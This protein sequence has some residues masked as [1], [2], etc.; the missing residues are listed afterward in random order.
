MYMWWRLLLCLVVAPAATLRTTAVIR[1]TTPPVAKITGAALAAAFAA[2]ND[3][4]EPKQ[5]LTLP[6]KEDAVVEAIR[7]VIDAGIARPRAAA[8]ALG[9]FGRCSGALAQ[10][11]L[12]PQQLESCFSFW[13]GGSALLARDL[14]RGNL[15]LGDVKAS[16]WFGLL[17]LNTFPWTP[18]LV[19]LVSRAIN[20]TDAGSFTPKSFSLR[21]LAALR[22]LR[23]DEGLP[24]T[25][26]DSPEF[27]T[28]QNIDEGVRFF[29]DGFTM[30]TRDVRLGRLGARGDTAAA[31]GWFLLL[32][33]STFPLTPL[34]LPIIDKRRD[35]V[36]SDY[37][38]SA[39]RAR[40]L[41]TF[42][43]YRTL[44][45]SQ[46]RTAEDILRAATAVPSAPDSDHA[47]PEPAETLAAIAALDIQSSR[48]GDF[49]AH[50]TEPGRRWRLIYTAGAGAV[51][52]AR[53][54]QKQLRTAAHGRSQVEGT[55]EDSVREAPTAKVE[56][57]K[58][59]WLDGA[60]QAFLPWTRLKDGLYV[61][62]LVTAVQRFDGTT[63]ENENGIFA[64]LG[65]ES[66][67]FTVR[68][69]FK[70]PDAERRT[71]CAFQPNTAQCKL[72]P[73]EWEFALSP[74][75]AGPD[76][77]SSWTDRPFEEVPV[78]KLPFFKFLLVDDDIAVAQ[79]RSGGVAVCARVTT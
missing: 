28:P 36:Q 48:R 58:R 56:V 66:I 78:T 26:T 11:W 7:S 75:D 29:S 16:P 41:S 25:A 18:L 67:R 63:G 14:R 62:G 65:M 60:S 64:V 71:V 52:D 43:R 12:T 46:A 50:L 22:R 70:W 33:F 13:S 77:K 2:K 19:P 3:G 74:G 15:A 38:P 17:V 59:T 31:Y 32:S 24:S 34:I 23:Q 4:T 72:G 35:G 61:D 53:K 21:R 47:R 40:R 68:G 79:G 69:P 51:Q 39:F 10:S 8:D 30:L 37:V 5:E 42:A 20:A 9:E 1:R 54:Q 57:P 49:Y 55:G 6:E 44:R 76:A 45:Q 73:L 27:R